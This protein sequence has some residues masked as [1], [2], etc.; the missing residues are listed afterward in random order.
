MHMYMHMYTHAACPACFDQVVVQYDQTLDLYNQLLTQL[1]FTLESEEMGGVNAVLLA[2]AQE[3]MRTLEDLLQ[4][5]MDASA[6]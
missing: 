1:N 4:R 5:A 3:Y 6:R 2:R